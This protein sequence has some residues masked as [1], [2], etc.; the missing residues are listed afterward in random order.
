MQRNSKKEA[1]LLL[2]LNLSL[3]QIVILNT[4]VKCIPVAAVY[5]GTKSERD[6]RKSLRIALLSCPPV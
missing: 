2:L 4:I 6:D 3:Y 1:K 5:D